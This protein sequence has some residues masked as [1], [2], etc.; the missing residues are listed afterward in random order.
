MVDLMKRYFQE[1]G[2]KACCF[3]DLKPYLALKGE[4]AASWTSFLQSLSPSFASPVDYI[5]QHPRLFDQFRRA[6]MISGD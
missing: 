2:D 1:I 6:L 4:D 3:E 5:Q